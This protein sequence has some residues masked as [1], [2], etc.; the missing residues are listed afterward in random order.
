[1]AID[2]QGKFLFILNGKSNNI[3]MFQIDQASGALSEVPAS[4]FQVPPTINPNLAPS[5]PIS[6][7]AEKSGKFLFVGY[8]LGDIPGLSAVVSLAI[9]TSGLSPVLV[10]QH[11]IQTNTGGAPAQLLADPKG[12]HLYVGL[13][14][15][16]NKLQIGGAE[17]YSI[18][19]ASGTL[20]YLGLADSPPADEGRQESLDV[21]SRS[22]REAL[23][24]LQCLRRNS[25]VFSVLCIGLWQC[26]L[27]GYAISLPAANRRHAV[28][29]FDDHA[30]DIGDVFVRDAAPAPAC[31]TDADSEVVSPVVISRR[32]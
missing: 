29:N 26:K 14:Q 12:L 11:S 2:G 19:P 9:D 5:Q 31:S 6:I 18:D 28:G 1:M 3:S 30:Y 32:T 8:F 13:S 27:D 22:S 7:A 17:V 10:T 25:L 24:V 21:R 16:Q 15:G 23:G 20:G 4:P